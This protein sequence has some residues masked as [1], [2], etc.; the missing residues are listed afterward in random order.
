L[1]SDKAAPRKVLE[2]YAR[3][4]YTE[5][6]LDPSN[7]AYAPRPNRVVLGDSVVFGY[8][9]RDN[10]LVVLKIRLKIQSKISCAGGAQDCARYKRA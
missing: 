7:F 8:G 9:Q 5:S 10:L 2:S 3:T 6:A 4:R 1:L